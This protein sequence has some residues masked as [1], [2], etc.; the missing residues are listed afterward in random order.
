MKKPGRHN[1]S[2][3]KLNVNSEQIFFLLRMILE[4]EEM[5]FKQQ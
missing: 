3:E 1:V 5:Q 4:V 2:P